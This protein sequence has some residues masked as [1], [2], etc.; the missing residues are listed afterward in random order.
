MP[1]PTLPPTPISSTD[2]AGKNEAV[3]GQLDSSFALPPAA[4][5]AHRF[6]TGKNTGATLN[7]GISSR[8]S[9]VSSA[10][11]SVTQPLSP[12][13]PTNA[14]TGG[15]SASRRRKASSNHLSDGRAISEGG[16]ASACEDVWRSGL[17]ENKCNLPPPPTRLRKIIQMRPRTAKDTSSIS[18]DSKS[19]SGSGSNDVQHEAA[20]SKG[21]RAAETIAVLCDSG[22][23]TA[24]LK[25]G[26]N[27]RSTSVAGRKSA[28]RTAHSLI[29]RRRRSKMNEEFGVLK[30]MIPACAGQEMHKLAILQVRAFAKIFLNAKTPAVFGNDVYA[31]FVLVFIAM[32]MPYFH[33]QPIAW[34]NCMLIHGEEGDHVLVLITSIY[35]QQFSNLVA[36][37]HTM[38][39]S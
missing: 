6:S 4:L 34:S 31:Y 21:S 3:L 25:H 23:G 13:L 32:N 14:T 20:T 12:S 7:A 16:S 39:R 30:S 24:R 33:S 28:R 29:E 38:K 17:A 15:T 10:S 11:S 37:M 22:E 2:I 9:K 36:N 26:S 35:L 8:S 5:D 1:E 27:A 18:R 19:I